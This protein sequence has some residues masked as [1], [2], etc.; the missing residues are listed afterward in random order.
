[1]HGIHV[2]TFAD[3]HVLASRLSKRITAVSKQLKKLIS[4]YNENVPLSEQL[5]WQSA[6]DLSLDQQLGRSRQAGAPDL[7][8]GVKHQA[9]KQLQ[10][11]KRSSEEIIRL[12]EDMTNCLHH[13]VGELQ[14]LQAVQSEPYLSA[15]SMLKLGSVCLINKHIS[16]SQRR[17][18]EL[19]SKFASFIEIPQSH[20]PVSTLPDPV[21]PL[22]S[23]QMQVE[24]SLSQTREEALLQCDLEEESSIREPNAIEKQAY[25]SNDESSDEEAELSGMFTCNIHQGHM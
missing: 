19:T 2:I 15:S 18:S 4:A 9:V 16:Q 22:P 10:L 17:L 14:Q 6:N 7:P 1:M 8:A 11:V 5:T 20:V 3:G 13:Y 25:L 12:K 24:A 23:D 21:S